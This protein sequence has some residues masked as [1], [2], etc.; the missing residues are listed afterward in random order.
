MHV[1][2]WHDLNMNECRQHTGK[3]EWTEAVLDWEPVR[4]TPWARIVRQR[5]GLPG[6]VR[7]CLIGGCLGV[8]GRLI[9]A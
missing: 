2:S 1:E 7:L 8:V 4:D 5:G 3:D 9:G 6:R